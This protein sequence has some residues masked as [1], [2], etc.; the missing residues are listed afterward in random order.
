MPP[1]KPAEQK[2]LTGRSPGRDAGGR[3]LPEPVVVLSEAIGAPR[4]PATL[5]ESGRA[6]WQRLWTAGRSWLSADVDLLIMERL[7][8]NHDLRAAMLAQVERD[9][10]TVDG[11]KGQPRPH[12]LL[13][14]V[15]AVEAEMRKLE[16][17][18]GFT[19]AARSKLGY[20]EVRRVSKLDELAQRRRKGSTL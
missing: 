19:P 8:E 3:K 5:K 4:P 16:I 18:C 6:E 15:R 10:L 20:A 11:Y 9:G 2:R 7:C 12:P 17:E 13:S 14:H 1:R